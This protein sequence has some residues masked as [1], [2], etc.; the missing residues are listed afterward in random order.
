MAICV[1]TQMRATRSTVVACLRG[2]V[3]HKSQS[4]MLIKSL[5][6]LAQSDLSPVLLLRRPNK[7]PFCTPRRQARGRGGLPPQ[8]PPSPGAWSVLPR[9]LVSSAL[10]QVAAG[11]NDRRF[12]VRRG[13]GAAR[14]HGVQ[15]PTAVTAKRTPP[16]F[17]AAGSCRPSGHLPPLRPLPLAH[18]QLLH[19]QGAAAGRWLLATRR[20]VPRRW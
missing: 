6:S 15:G 17:S 5:V 12:P 7:A 13:G 2:V 8:P 11:A 19:P 14:G 1:S 3:H 18:P 9:W 16:E 4:W 20:R 10:A